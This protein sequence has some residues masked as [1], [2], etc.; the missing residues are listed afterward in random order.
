MTLR[1]CC[2]LPQHWF[3]SHHSLSASNT[4]PDRLFS[5]VLHC[6]KTQSRR[7]QYVRLSGRV[8]DFRF[9]CEIFGGLSIRLV[10]HQTK[11]RC[12]LHTVTPSEARKRTGKGKKRRIWLGSIARKRHM[13]LCSAQHL[14]STHRYFTELG[15]RRQRRSSMRLGETASRDTLNA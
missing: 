5:S 1:E 14:T 10:A 9:H 7:C 15:K 4:S 8:V 13:I 12:G 11:V 6:V 3:V 2:G